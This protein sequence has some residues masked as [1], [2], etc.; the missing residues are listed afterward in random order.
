MQTSLEPSVGYLDPP[1]NPMVTKYDLILTGEGKHVTLTPA[2]TEAAASGSIHLNGRPLKS[3]TTSQ[4]L[5]LEYTWCEGLF[6]C[7]VAMRETWSERPWSH[8]SI[9]GPCAAV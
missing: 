1:F 3:G 7:C 4:E 6:A 8:R 5:H 2:L 9:Q